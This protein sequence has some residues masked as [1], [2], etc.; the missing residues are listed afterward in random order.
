VFI[1]KLAQANL[2]QELLG[3]LAPLLPTNSL[4]HQAERD[5]IGG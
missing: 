3:A 2:T 4:E 5:I 1:G